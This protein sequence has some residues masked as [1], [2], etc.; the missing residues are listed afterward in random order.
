M[1]VR[2][3]SG[4]HRGRVAQYMII[5]VPPTCTMGGYFILTFGIQWLAPFL[6]LAF[7]PVLVAMGAVALRGASAQVE[8]SGDMLRVRNAFGVEVW[9]SPVEFLTGLHPVT[10]TISPF[11]P[12]PGRMVITSESTRPYVLDL[13]VWQQSDLSRLFRRLRETPTAEDHWYDWKG[14]KR[15]FPG[16]RMPWHQ[17]HPWSATL[18]LVALAVAFLYAYAVLAM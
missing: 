18:L 8:V 3:D 11:S 4:L 5:V 13:R 10:T 12:A 16:V 14:L 2:P 7:V 6:L 17:S 9:R 1:V 15:A